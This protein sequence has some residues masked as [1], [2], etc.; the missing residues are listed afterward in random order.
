MAMANMTSYY[1]EVNQNNHDVKIK[2]LEDRVQQ[3]EELVNRLTKSN[4]PSFMDFKFINEEEKKDEEGKMSDLMSNRDITRM[5][6]L[7]TK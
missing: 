4:K 3:L 7:F 1:N 2:E 6:R 5:R